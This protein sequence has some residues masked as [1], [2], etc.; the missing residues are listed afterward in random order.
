M[1]DAA[2]VAIEEAA[3]GHFAIDTFP[4]L[5]HLPAWFPGAGFQT[6]FAQCKAACDHLKNVPFDTVK[7]AMVRDCNIYTGVGRLIR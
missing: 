7:D 2:F 4:F 6:A 1:I 3:H 5:R